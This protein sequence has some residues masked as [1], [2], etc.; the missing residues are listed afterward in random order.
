MTKR[1]LA[2][3]SALLLTAGA[4]G[5]QQ[6]APIPVPVLDPA[7]VQPSPAGPGGGLA[8]GAPGLYPGYA[9]SARLGMYVGGEAPR[10][11]AEA[12][13]AAAAGVP[14]EMTTSQPRPAGIPGLSDGRTLSA[15]KIDGFNAAVEENF[16]M[17]P[18]MARRYRDIYEENE[19]ALTERPEPKARVDAA[20]VSLEPGEVPSEFK[21]APGIASV[22]GFY[23]VTGQPWPV[24]K[25]VLGNGQNF[26]VVQLGEASNN[27]AITPLV[28]FGWTNL[29]VVLKGHSKPV[30]LRVTISEDS[31]HFRHD[32]QIMDRGPNAVTNT[33][34]SDNAVREAGSGLLLSALS[35]IDLPDDAKPVSISGVDARA[36]LVNG[37]VIIRSKH[38]MLAPTWENSLAGPDGIM[39]YD[40][41]RSSFALFSVN[42]KYTRA[43]IALP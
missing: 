16:P 4:A 3:M 31:A 30:V 24:T 21:V 6:S 36:W 29:I 38:P 26:E 27:V 19:R 23:D 32:I 8:G 14:A 9:P 22:I 34:T 35:G 37:R 28:R 10:D 43:E 33:A 18:E 41:A 5:A 25:Y 13:A 17:T 2:G 12:A 15:E 11:A 42:G 39:V 7:Q 40:I 1:Y 20:F